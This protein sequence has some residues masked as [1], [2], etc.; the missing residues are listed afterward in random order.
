MPLCE[1]DYFS[2]TLD[3]HCSMN[4]LLPENTTGDLGVLYLL[5]GLGNTYKAWCKW[6]S[7]PRY[8]REQKFIIVMPD[9]HTKW[10]CNDPQPGGLDWE[11]HIIKDVIANVERFFPSEQ[12]ANRVLSQE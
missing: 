9:A 12:I 3:K 8:H 10:Y 7:L 11:D 6:T 4:I 1:L 5:H 2:E